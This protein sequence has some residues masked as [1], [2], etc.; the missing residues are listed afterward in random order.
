MTN[1]YEILLLAVPE[2]TGEEITSLEKELERVLKTHNGKV[3]SF[4]RWGKYKLSYPVRKNEY[5]V[6][7]LSRFEVEGDKAAAVDAVKT[8][9]AVKFNDIIMRSIISQLPMHAPLTYIRPDSLEEAPTREAS[10]SYMKDGRG[11]RNNMSSLQD[12]DS[13]DL[14]D[15]NS[16]AN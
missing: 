1:R 10:I 6:Y 5:G 3:L 2:I 4:E 8:L 16:S 11:G 15:F 14:V 12:S 7:F 13:S 9:Y